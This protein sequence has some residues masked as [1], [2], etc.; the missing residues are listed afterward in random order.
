V[1]VRLPNL[2][3]AGVTKAGTTSLFSYL[4]QHDDV[5]GS[6]LKE[7][8][9]FSKL[10]Y[11]DRELAPRREYERYF[12]HCG[13][14]RYVLEATPN[15]WYAGD[16]LLD[17]TEDM[18]GAPRYIISLRDPVERFWSDFT[19]MK[20]KVLLP[21][22]LSAGDYLS[23]C[24]ELRRDGVEFTEANRYYRTLSTGFYVEHLPRWIER[25]GARLRFVFFEDLVA[26][27]AGVVNG[28]FAWL[29]LA[30]MPAL[31]LAAQN[32][33]NSVRSEPI[34]RVAHRV[35]RLTDSAT[36]RY[37]KAKQVLV[38]AYERLNRGAPREELLDEA[39]RAR[40]EELFAPA[41]RALRDV[42]VAAGYDDLPKW[43]E[44]A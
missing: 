34:Q 3:I 23:R 6:S 40:L 8:E 33:T 1:S 32:T 39:T 25:L 42:L 14:E 41:N 24:E 22:E 28:V 26:D 2:L 15:Y 19:Y 30:P 9:Y 13:D 27:A 29:E 16:R 4:V 20:S 21:R 36:R 10:L 11:P 5:C 44:S 38:D 12:R 43:L 35:A 17:T 31:D 37:P 7:T 18:L